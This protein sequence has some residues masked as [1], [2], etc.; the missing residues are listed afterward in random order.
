M[1]RS[2]SQVANS[3]VRERERES[4]GERYGCSGDSG[5]GRGGGG[6]GG[7]GMRGLVLHLQRWRKPD[8]LD[9]TKVYHAHCVGK[10]I[11]VTKNEESF[12]CMRH[13]CYIC[14]RRPS[15]WCFCCP[16]AVCEGC[17]T[18]SEFIQLKEN[19][20]L[21]NQCQEYVVALEEIREYAA[22]GDK[23]DLL[24]R[25]TFECLF[26]EYWEIVK[27]EED[28]TFG[29]VRASKSQKK[30]AKPKY[31]DDPMFSLDDV[32][33]SKPRKKDIKRKDKD[34]LKFSL[35][36]R[37]VEDAEGYRTTGKAKRMEFIRWGSKPLI[38]FL[39]SIGEDTK[40]AMSQH[41]VESVI[42]RYIR[43]EKL[44]DPEKKKRVHCD[45]KLYSIFRKKTVNRKRIY[46]LLNAHLKENLEQLEY[47]TS[48]ERG[49]GE[50]SKEVLVPCKK[51]KAEVPDEE[52]CEEEV[53]PEM[54]PTGLAT[55]NADNIKL[56]YLRKSLILELLKQSES[57]GD[58][59]VGSFVKV[60][61]DP[62][63]LV[64]YR[65]LQVTGIKAA[66]DHGISLYVAGM[67]SDVSISKL[68]DSDLSK[69]DIE[70]LKKTVMSGQLRQP[71]VVEMEQKAKALHEDITKHYLDER[72]LLQK[73]SEQERL[74]RKTPRIVED[75]IEVKQEPGASSDS[76][77]QVSVSGLPQEL[78]KSKVLNYLLL[79][80]LF[81][82][83]VSFH[84]T[85]NWNSYFITW[86]GSKPVSLTRKRNPIQNWLYCDQLRHPDVFFSLS[87]PALT[88]SSSYSLRRRCLL[89]RVTSISVADFEVS[90]TLCSKREI[91]A[92]IEKMLVFL[93]DIV[94]AAQNNIN[95]RFI[96]L[97]KARLPAAA[98]NGQSCI[99]LA[100][101][102]T[103]AVHIQLW[104][105]ECDAFEAGDIVKLT[106]G[107]FSYVR[108]SGLL[109]RA[110]KRGKMEK[111][112]EF[113]AAFV[114]TPNVSEIQWIP[115]PDNP[116]RYIQNG[117]VSAYS[118][119]F[120]PLP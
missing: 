49:F 69:E 10:D 27:K 7:E 21:C 97:D 111:M 30:R 114:E 41:S 66:D 55:I 5:C 65:V 23:I 106:N 64:A 63:D 108:N 79:L 20:G 119:V 52:I 74:L 32:R 70:D 96:I 28:L 80:G 90:L 81:L 59:V 118:R 83:L 6:G 19:K 53:L 71:T 92:I 115:D 26:L 33:S 107:I 4:D 78:L 8:A 95:T 34:V 102:E 22:A 9:C 99:A 45:E 75:L 46:T 117:T 2:S 88:Q 3:I 40:D 67:T 47:V 29:D 76:S 50:K 73:P 31:R 72:E 68:D 16:N 56:V 77:K 14:S 110:G 37:E 87:S 91:L 44:L 25:N 17:V 89:H 109:L 62:R 57:F 112:G 100:A 113:T 51:Q 24:D 98:A 1:T 36:D 93:K 116:K 104:G 48:L 105:D 82:L 94:P 103:A 11:S 13:R 120:P 60:K 61:N 42:R 38:D 84:S 12:I 58:K 15:L 39:T 54:R 35:T 85:I 18:H 43:Q 86:T 101:D